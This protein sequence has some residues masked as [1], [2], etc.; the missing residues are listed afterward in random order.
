MKPQP[1]CLA[2]LGNKIRQEM[3]SQ[4]KTLE[5]A[6]RELGVELAVKMAYWML[7]G[8]RGE[9]NLIVHGKANN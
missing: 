3:D 1:V 9:H 2:C 6:K 7:L 8:F 5:D 4:G